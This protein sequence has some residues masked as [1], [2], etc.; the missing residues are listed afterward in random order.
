MR[1]VYEWECIECK[2]CELCRRTGNIGEGC[3]RGM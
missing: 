3:V 2:K 1:G